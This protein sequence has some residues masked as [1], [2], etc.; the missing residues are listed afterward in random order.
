MK[1]VLFTTTNLPASGCRPLAEHSNTMFDMRGADSR[2]TPI[3]LA[4][5]TRKKDW[6]WLALVYLM[7]LTPFSFTFI[8]F[9]LAKIP[10]SQ[11]INLGLAQVCH[12]LPHFLAALGANPH[13]CWAF[14]LK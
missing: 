6:R 2:Q 5:Q 10:P 8:P 7:N 9:I 12:F 4:R 14:G 13:E 1:L 11:C 3:C